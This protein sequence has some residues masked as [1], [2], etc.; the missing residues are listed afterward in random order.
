LKEDEIKDL[1]ASE[2]LHFVV[3]DVFQPLKWI[4]KQERFYFWKHDLKEHLCEYPKGCFR[5]DFKDEYFYYTS[6][7]ISKTE[8]L[9]VVEKYH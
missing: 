5:K 8:R 2:D 4:D 1:I 6:L 3:V 9:I 7:C